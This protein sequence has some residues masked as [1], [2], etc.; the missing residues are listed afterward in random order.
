[1]ILSLIIIII[2]RFK[3]I[4]SK[5]TYPY[6]IINENKIS[7]KTENINHDLMIEKAIDELEQQ[8]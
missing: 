1:M 3:I 4:F 8:F 2:L 7:R 5:V 6:I